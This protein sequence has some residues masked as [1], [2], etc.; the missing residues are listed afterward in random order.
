VELHPNE[1][2]PRLHLSVKDGALVIRIPLEPLNAIVRATTL[3]QTGEFAEVANR[4]IK[5][6]KAEVLDIPRYPEWGY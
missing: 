4:V 1:Q 5:T 3:M 6:G 2:L